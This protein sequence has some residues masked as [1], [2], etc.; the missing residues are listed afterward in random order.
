MK[1]KVGRHRGVLT[2][3]GIWDFVKED[4]ITAVW[5]AYELGQELKSERV[6]FSGWTPRYDGIKVEQV[7]TDKKCAYEIAR[8]I[9]EKGKTREK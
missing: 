9:I 6:F 4:A 3:Y 5:M 8:E 1:L 7:E 2:I